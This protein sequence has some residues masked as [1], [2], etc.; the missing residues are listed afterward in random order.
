ME[1][2]T[3]LGDYGHG[4]SSPMATPFRTSDIDFRDVFGGPPRRSSIHEMMRYS[5]TEG[6]DALSSGRRLGETPS[7]GDPWTLAEE[8]PVFGGRMEGGNRRRGLREDFFVDIFGGSESPSSTTP[9]KH[10]RDLFSASPPGSR[11]LSPAWPLPPQAEGF[12]GPSSVPTQFRFLSDVPLCFFPPVQLFM[13]HFPMSIIH[14]TCQRLVIG[15][16]ALVN[17]DSDDEPKVISKKS[18]NNAGNHP[19]DDQ[20]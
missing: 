16:L 18:E 11:P 13:I 20:E 1:A 7:F 14:C 15:L 4:Y 5:F 3:A 19:S 2:D 8:K 9:R 10:D 6:A 12:V 17:D